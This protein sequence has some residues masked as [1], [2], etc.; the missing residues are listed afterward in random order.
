MIPDAAPIFEAALAL[1]QRLRAD[2]AAK[3]LQS[4]DDDISK[5]TDRT[6]EEWEALINARCEALERGETETID[7]E[8][9]AG[10]L[11][12]IIDRASRSS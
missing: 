5:I 1:P 11:Q 7:G 8:F 9:V 3:L 6:P 12:E 4:L 2:L 10:M